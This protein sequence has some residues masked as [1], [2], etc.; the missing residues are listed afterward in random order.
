MLDTILYCGRIKYNK[1]RK[2]CEVKVMNKA[3]CK[4]LTVDDE[5]ELTYIVTDILKREGYGR[6]DSAANLKEAE[7][8]IRENT[9][10]LILLDVMLPDGRGFELYENMKKEGYMYEVP[11]IFLSARDEDVDR[12]H[13]LGLG[14]DDYITKP[15]LPQ[16]LLLRIGAVLRRTY[17]LEKDVNMVRLGERTVS[18]EAG[19]VRYKGEESPLTAKELALFAILAKNRGKIVTTDTLCDALWPDGS[20]GLESSL[21]VHMRHLREKIEE[22]PSKPGFLKTVRGLG[23]KLEKEQ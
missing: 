13:G 20:Y 10:H 3:E 16:E 21:I 17:H 12:L 15:F 5:K 6:I 14:A 18:I 8:K 9:Y 23:Y 19:T 7:K 1:V 11:V 4:I 2:C 22:E